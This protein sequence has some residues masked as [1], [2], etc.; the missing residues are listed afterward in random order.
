MGEKLK[1]LKLDR[2]LLLFTVIGAFIGIALFAGT[3]TTLEAT[4]TGEFCSTCHIMERAYETFSN[5][6][7]SVLKCNDCHLPHDNTV[8]KLTFKAKAGMSHMYM[9]TL[10]SNQVPDVIRAKEESTEVVLENCLRCHE[11]SVE[12]V[13]AHEGQLVHV[14]I[15]TGKYRMEAATSDRQIG[16]NQK[17]FISQIRINKRRE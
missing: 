3:A 4:D 16:L 6:N 11:P 1:K 2:K 15:V 7:H 10:G 14:S 13:S 5:T 17:N 9:N 12:N 8:S